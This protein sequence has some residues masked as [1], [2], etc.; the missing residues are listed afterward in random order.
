MMGDTSA[1]NHATPAHLRTEDGE[2]EVPSLFI[3]GSTSESST[4][5]QQVDARCSSSE[6][7]IT[8]ATSDRETYGIN[9]ASYAI[10]QAEKINPGKF[11][12]SP[13]YHGRQKQDGNNQAEDSKISHGR[14]NDFVDA[15]KGWISMLND[16]PVVGTR[17]E[18][19]IDSTFDFDELTSLGSASTRSRFSRRFE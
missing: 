4:V 19:M 17:D 1:S 13:T 11:P 5:E 16:T 6:E 12:D 15:G 8:T 2:I 10:D 7:G 9:V 18:S 14:K 3:S